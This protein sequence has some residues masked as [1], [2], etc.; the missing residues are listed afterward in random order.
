M[1]M[2]AKYKIDESHGLSHA[3]QILTYANDIYENEVRNIPELKK[4]E[5]VIY[6]AAIVHDMCDNKYMNSETGLNTIVFFLSTNEEFKL[7]G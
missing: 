7:K 5:K 1:K 3:F 6:I 2:V 4:H